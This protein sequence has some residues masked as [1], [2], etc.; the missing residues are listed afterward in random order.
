M[1]NVNKYTR[2][3]PVVLRKKD[4]EKGINGITGYVRQVKESLNIGIGHAS[5]AIDT[6]KA[7][8]DT[9][10]TNTL[11]TLKEKLDLAGIDVRNCENEI[12]KIKDGLAKLP[13]RVKLTDKNAIIMQSFASEMEAFP[14]YVKVTTDTLAG[15][16]TAINMLRRQAYGDANKPDP[17]LQLPNPPTPIDSEPV[18]NHHDSQQTT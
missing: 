12:T 17:T 6:I 2:P 8:G 4:L 13:P 15:V 11:Q 10:D 14:A 7:R 9:V 18:V 16:D 1:S 5:Q 3:A